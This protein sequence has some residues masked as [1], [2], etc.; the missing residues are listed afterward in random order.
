MKI[1]CKICNKE[2][3]NRSKRFCSHRCQTQY[4]S[5]KRYYKLKNN[6]D[7]KKKA[8][9]NWTRWYQNHRKKYNEYMKNYMYKK[10][11]DKNGKYKKKQK[12]YYL[13][14]Y[15]EKKEQMKNKLIGNKKNGN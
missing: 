14:K 2:I 3:K 1:K 4:N 15:K 10:T 8:K 13:K 6:P 7:F 11:R 9:D 5:L 12:E